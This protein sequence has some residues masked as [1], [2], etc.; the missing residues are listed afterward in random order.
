MIDYSEVLGRLNAYRKKLNMSKEEMSRMFGVHPTHY[1][2]LEAGTIR[3]SFEGLTNFICQGGDIYY[4]FTGRERETGPIGNYLS[5]CR[6]KDGREKLLHILISYIELGIWMDKKE[7]A[8]E[9]LDDIGRKKVSLD[10][11]LQTKADRYG[12]PSTVHKSLRLMEMEEDGLTIWKR[13]RMVESLTQIQM[14]KVLDI[15]VK[16]YRQLEKGKTLP[17]VEIIYAM[18]CRLDYSP[19]LFFDRDTFYLDELNYY[20]NRLSGES[21]Q[22]LETLLDSVIHKIEENEIR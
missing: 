19:Q 11:A 16:R 14:A 1:G 4:L 13:I 5:E 9:S 15:D 21:K 8:K 2:K 7:N 20:W 10:E 12:M 3:I 22:Y 18:Y 6:T 17:T